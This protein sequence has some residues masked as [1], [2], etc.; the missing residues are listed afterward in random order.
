MDNDIHS[1]WEP[2]RPRTS[3]QLFEET[4]VLASKYFNF[5][6]ID[7]AQAMLR[8]QIPLKRNS[9]VITFDDGQLNNVKLA[10]PILRKYK[11]PVVLYL[12]TAGL[13]RPKPFWFDRLDYAIQQSGI[14]GQIIEVGSTRIV[15]D[16]SSRENMA[17]SLAQ[18]TKSLKEEYI[19]DTSFQHAVEEVIRKLEMASGKSLIDVYDG[20]LWSSLMSKQDVL[21]CMQEDDVTIGSHTIN[22]VRLS[23]ADDDEL[24]KEVTESKKILEG[25]MERPCYHFCYPNGDWDSKSMRA[26]E[27]AGYTTAVTTDPGCNQV[28]DN[29][30][31]LK[32]YS[33]PETGTP[34]RALFSIFGLLHFVS[35]VRY[36]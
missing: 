24:V 34:I 33:F 20:D 5:V 4:L 7:E 2:L 17:S 31:N 18:L 1:K 29:L 11:I 27:E 9:C 10:L 8:G 32:R 30:F 6:S 22:H 36:G 12:T 3:R 35:T 25:L 15:V 26:V 21:D 13:E 19:S 28:G 16:Q 23:L 14:H